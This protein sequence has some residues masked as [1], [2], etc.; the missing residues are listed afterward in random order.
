M[1]VRRK[2][3]SR[4]T[5]KWIQ[6][7][8]DLDEVARRRCLM[9][10]SVLSGERPVTEAIAEAQISRQLYYLLEDKALRAMLAVLTPSSTGESAV[11]VAESPAKR[12]AELEAKVSKL[13]KDKRRSE[14]LLLLTRKI[15]RPGPIK[16]SSGGRPSAAS[17]SGR[18][19]RSSTTRGPKPSPASRATSAT[20]TTEPETPSTPTPDGEGGR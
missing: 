8:K 12:I 6:T 9:V 1:P 14:R 15:V 20:A 3:R 4:G 2:A 7:Q 18:R 10:L 17:R 5:P 19:G 11:S 16:T 13:E